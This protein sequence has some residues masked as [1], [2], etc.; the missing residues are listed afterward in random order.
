MYIHNTPI[1]PVT[2][3]SVTAAHQVSSGNTVCLLKPGEL[4]AN[5]GESQASELLQADTNKVV[6]PPYQSKHEETFSSGEYSIK[7]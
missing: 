2:S 7:S 5:W 4:S 6:P 3:V 1:T